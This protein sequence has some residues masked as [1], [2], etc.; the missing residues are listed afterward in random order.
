MDIIAQKIPTLK[1]KWTNK[2]TKYGNPITMK[3]KYYGCA[4]NILWKVAWG[5]KEEWMFIKD[6]S[7]ASSYI[8]LFQILNLWKRGFSKRRG[9]HLIPALDQQQV[10][11]SRWTWNLDFQA[12]R[13]PEGTFATRHIN[14]L[15]QM[16]IYTSG[17]FC[18]ACY[19]GEMPSGCSLR[20]LRV[21]AGGLTAAC[22]ALP[23]HQGISPSRGVSSDASPP[24][25]GTAEYIKVTFLQLL[26]LGAAA[27][28]GGRRVHWAR[29]V[30][31]H[32]NVAWDWHQVRRPAAL[33]ASKESKEYR[34]A[35]T[36][37]S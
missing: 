11:V 27:A 32:G 4:S 30:A 3:A 22:A 6:H 7:S 26:W 29:R 28:W 17:W 10:S 9:T 18:L 33:A 20:S 25:R 14:L 36:T 37:L 16:S 5:K 21:R 15:C 31:A 13:S 1:N 12:L 34:H 23:P 24:G 2:H 19:T 35:F 8:H